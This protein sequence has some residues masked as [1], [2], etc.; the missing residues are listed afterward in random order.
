[1]KLPVKVLQ[2]LEF[3]LASGVFAVKD[4]PGL[5]ADSQLVLARHL[6]KDGYLTV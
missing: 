1:V 6:V 5:N 2:S 3:I 4:I